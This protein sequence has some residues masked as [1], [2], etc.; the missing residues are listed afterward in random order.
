M[1]GRVFLYST[2]EATKKVLFN[3]SAIK[4]GAGKGRAIK[5]K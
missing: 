1:L 5:K 2:K 4:E 3:V